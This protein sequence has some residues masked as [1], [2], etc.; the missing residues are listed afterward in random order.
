MKRAGISP[1]KK[2][3]QAAVTLDIHSSN[4]RE[5]FKD[6]KRTNSFSNNQA[7]RKVGVSMRESIDYQNTS[8]NQQAKQERQEDRSR[9]YSH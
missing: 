2:A 3:K 5:P 7:K 8:Y 1:Y 6:L 9:Q 4:E